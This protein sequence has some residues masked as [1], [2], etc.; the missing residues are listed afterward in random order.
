MSLLCS[1]KPENILNNSDGYIKI[2]DFGLSK[3]NIC[4]N[5]STNSL[6]GTPEYL[7]P[8]TVE[9]KGHGQAVDWWSFGCIIYEMLVGAPPFYSESV[10]QLFSQIKEAKVK[11]K[12]FMSEEVVDLLQKLFVKEPDERLGS[13]P[14]GV[15]NIKAHPFFSG[16]DWNAIL[17]KKI[18]PP[19]MPR[20]GCE[21]N[22]R[23]FDKNFTMQQTEDSVN[24][25]ES[26]GDSSASFVGFSYDSNKTNGEVE[27]KQLKN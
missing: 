13:G 14:D 15:E 11:Y 19:F 8:E 17:N 24:N 27:A 22:L 3:N 4:D 18:K 21:V 12:N 26:V 5:H 6:C 25:E 2:T 16:V 10:E 1:L 9:Q 7:S 23:Y 20:E